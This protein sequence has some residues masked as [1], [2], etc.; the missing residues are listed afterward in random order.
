MLDLRYRTILSVAL[1]LMVSSFIQSV[2]MLTDTA[3]LSR[4][5]TLAFDAAGNAGLLYITAFMALAG[6]GDG[7]QILIARRIGQNNTAAIGRIF[8]T[9]ILIHS[10]LAVLL[11]CVL[12]FIVPDML[13][14]Y[15][16]HKAIASAQIDFLGIRSYALFFAMISLSI[17]A[18][19]LATGKTWVVLISAIITAFSNVL[20]DYLLIFGYGSFPEMGLR[21]AAYA[22]TL[23]DG[24]GMLF[25]ICFLLFSKLRKKYDLFA[26]FS[27]NLLSFKELIKIGSPILLQG[28]IALSTWTVF[29]TWIEQIGTFE[30]TVS[31]NIRSIYFLAFIPIWGFAGTTK[32]YI[33]QYIGK[34]D[35]LSLKIIQRKI[36]WLTLLFL[37]IILLGAAFFP[38]QLIS[39]INPNKDYLQKSVDILRFIGG[40]TLLFGFMNVYFQTI[41]GSGNT[42]VTFAIE[43]ISVLVYI[44][45]SYLLIKV[46]KL[47]IFWV[48][49][50]EYIYFGFMGGLSLAYLH[51]FDWK[52]KVV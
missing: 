17:Q 10:L 12:Q 40:S 19:F 35:F 15:S 38:N 14:S 31:Q 48:W 34:G 24:S 4:Y 13:F 43:V 42:M 1:P 51:F 26:H 45:S 32:T 18:F 16:K 49:S 6:M 9:S 8:G 25:L 39:T 30:L 7:A 27:F 5:S 50:V 3:F 36:Q 21:G 22:S 28:V 2:V 33:S 37:S 11:L 52:K 44:I 46:Y 29:F 23:A 41:N 47:D 20:L